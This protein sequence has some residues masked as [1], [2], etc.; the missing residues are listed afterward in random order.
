MKPRHITLGPTNVTNDWN[1]CKCRLNWPV[2]GVFDEHFML[3]NLGNC[4]W[5]SFRKYA[6]A[7]RDFWISKKKCCRDMSNNN[8]K[9]VLGR[10]WN[11]AFWKSKM[12]MKHAGILN[13]IM[14]NRLVI[15]EWE[16]LYVAYGPSILSTVVQDWP[17][18]PKTV[19][20]YFCRVI[21]R[22]TDKTIR[23]NVFVFQISPWRSPRWLPTWW[24]GTGMLTHS[25]EGTYQ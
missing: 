3:V 4:K 12:G 5:H 9:G 7:C 6:W 19:K 13:I 10:P 2:Y 16:Y 23:S 25:S 1:L 8:H 20:P 17:T 24:V 18:D 21:Y 15:S 22:A 14:S 11:G